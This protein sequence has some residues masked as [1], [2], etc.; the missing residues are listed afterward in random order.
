MEY[1]ASSK[2]FPG[3]KSQAA[4]SSARSRQVTTLSE[5]GITHAPIMLAHDRRVLDVPLD[6]LEGTTEQL[7]TN[8]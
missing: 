1:S 5:N 8:L 7:N 4:R 2:R 3:D 6:P